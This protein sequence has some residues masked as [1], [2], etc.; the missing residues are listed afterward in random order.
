MFSSAEVQ[1]GSPARLAL[2]KLKS[3]RSVS[4]ISFIEKVK[5]HQGR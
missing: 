4:V 1:E 3:G 2:A 5:L